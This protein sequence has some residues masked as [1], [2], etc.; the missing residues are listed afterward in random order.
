MKALLFLLSLTV[1]TAAAIKTV[2]LMDRAT[3]VLEQALNQ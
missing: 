1:G 2:D 3:A